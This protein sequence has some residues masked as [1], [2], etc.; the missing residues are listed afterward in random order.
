MRRP[1]PGLALPALVAVLAGCGG[2]AAS[3]SPRASE[4]PLIHGASIVQEVKQCDR[5]AN[6]FCAIEMVVVD[7]RLNSSGALVYGE[8]HRLRQ[9]GWSLEAG[10]TGPQ[11]AADSPSHALRVVYATAEGDLEGIDMSWIERPRAIALTLAKE[12]FDRVPAMSVMLETGPS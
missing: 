9:D 7:Q 12:M 2:T 6:A 1:R 4:L 8:R 3:R 11:H 10:D 5:G